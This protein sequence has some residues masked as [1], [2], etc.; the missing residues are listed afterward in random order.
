MADAEDKLPN[1]DDDEVGGESTV[2][3]ASP[4]F[5]PN[6]SG[7][8]L[9]I[10]NPPPGLGAGNGP[11]P[12]QVP[13]TAPFPFTPPGAS[14]AAAKPPPLANPPPAAS[15]PIATPQGSPAFPSA[16]RGRG[17]RS[18]TVIGIAPP[19]PGAKSPPAFGSS[20]SAAAP[21]PS[22]PSPMTPVAPVAPKIGAARPGTLVGTGLPSGGLAPP[23]LAPPPLAPPVMPAA[24]RKPVEIGAVDEISAWDDVP[25][26]H[27]EDSPTMA[28]SPEESLALF[29][30]DEAAGAAARAASR[31]PGPAAGRPVTSPL[32][33]A[34]FAP[35][36]STSGGLRPRL[37]DSR[38]Q[39]EKETETVAVSRSDFELV[40]LSPEPDDEEST[41][42]VPREELLRGQQDAQLIVG[43][44]AA[45][46]DATLAVAPGANEASKNLAAFAETMQG[47]PSLGSPLGGA[48]P[49]PSPAQ[50]P[51]SWGGDPNAGWGMGAPMTGPQSNPHL[52]HPP[53]S[54]NP[55]MQPSSANP[56]M[57][58]S[59]PQMM[60]APGQMQLPSSGHLPVAQ[61]APGGRGYHQPGNPIP[62][63]AHMVHGQQ[64]SPWLMP[65]PG[66]KRFKIS[67]Q[68]L[69]LAVVGFVC[70]AVFITGIVL[71]ATTKL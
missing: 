23:P 35:S 27:K 43:D 46:E 22:P 12:L 17:G 58:G 24:G 3:M 48:F 21:V 55:Y 34:N 50:N 63:P 51:P 5:D 61:N 38:G 7:M 19:A 62:Y 2:A 31:G 52:P 36:S 6:T 42:A 11:P 47:D 41:R 40:R 69:L 1:V 44:D 14:L 9:P 57:P 68:I 16:L 15:A 13:P 39:P 8:P 65:G 37:S 33:N 25:D 70:L 49:P 45:G 10:S 56:H 18:Q 28:G 26:S 64:G 29:G 66:G 71:F 4:S 59:N 67:G 32:A 20:P 54:P 53:S 60:V 30:L